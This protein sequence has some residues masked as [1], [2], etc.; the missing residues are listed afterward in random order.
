MHVGHLLPFTFTAWLQSVFKCVV[1]IQLTDDE[2][3]L[4]KKNLT[5][6][7]T[8]TMAKE[9]ARDIIAVGFDKAR[10]FIFQNTEYLGHMYSTV[11][12]VQRKVTGSTVRAVFGFENSHN[13][14][15]FAFPA[16]QAAPAFASA[17]PHIFGDRK[18][19]RCLIP[20]AIDQDAYFRVTRDVAESKEL[21]FPKPALIHS[22]FFPALQGLRTKM[23]SSS[24]NSVIQLTDTANQIKKK[25]NKHAFSGGRETLE[26]QRKHGANVDVDIP[27]HYLTFFLED[28][29]QLEQIRKDYSSG[30]M[31]SGEVKKTLIGVLQAEVGAFQERRAAVTDDVLAEYFER[32]PLDFGGK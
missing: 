8:T 4:W 3:Y 7:D 20:Q 21:P 11:L 28:D 24:V 14:G 10:T 2:K 22:K 30:A 17:F 19:V 23:S 26:E 18:D 31:L 13:I 6:E 16:I 27:Y 15:Q 9:N 25:I 32:R 29:D 5:L 12:R 1:V